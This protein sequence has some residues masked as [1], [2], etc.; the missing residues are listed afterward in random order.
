MRSAPIEPTTAVPDDDQP[1]AR[2]PYCDR[3]FESERA[4]AL[5]VGEAHPDRLTADECDAYEEASADEDHE[6][7]V[8]HLKVVV[9]LSAVYG[10]FAFTYTIV[11][12]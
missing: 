9:A 6:L 3:P 7:L 1:A 11:L 2:C 10:A 4:G 12:A 5:H 8:Y